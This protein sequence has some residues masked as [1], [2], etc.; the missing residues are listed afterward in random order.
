[1]VD[2]TH[3][4]V[5]GL[6]DRITEKGG[7]AD[8]HARLVVKLVEEVDRHANG[9]SHRGVTL[10]VVRIRRR[11][12]V[13]GVQFLRGD[14]QDF[15]RG[16]GESQHLRAELVR[17]LDGT[18]GLSPEGDEIA[19]IMVVRMLNRGDGAPVSL[20]DGVAKDYDW[21]DVV[22]HVLELVIQRDDSVG[23]RP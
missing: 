7:G 10:V 2:G 13:R 11:R 22:Q 12:A 1:M 18:R 3:D 20:L 5:V 21:P 16:V 14:G 6:L 17:H 8:Q 19:G 4:A 9:R 23:R 15:I